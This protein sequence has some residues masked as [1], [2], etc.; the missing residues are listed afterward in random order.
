MFLLPLTVYMFFATGVNLFEK[1][2]VVS[3]QVNEINNFQ[4][5][6][7][8]L[9]NNITILGFLG[10][11]VLNKRALV[12]NLAHKIYKPYYQ[13]E[14]LQFVWVVNE[15]QQEEVAHLVVALEQIADASKWKFIYGSDAQIHTF[16]KSL[17]SA[18]NLDEFAS[19]SQ[20][21]IIDKERNLRGRDPQEAPTE[22]IGYDISTPAA[23]NN[24]LLDDVK[25]LLA[26]YRLALKD[27]NRYKRK[28]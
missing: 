16:F 14:D 27:N 23:I 17:H 9:Q 19:S 10:N 3:P 24:K 21:Y 12:Y 15:N 28:I 26:E 8:Q 20:V 1:L 6:G 18:E 22:T 7:V 4:S 2:P 11:D 5:D 25:I 13:F